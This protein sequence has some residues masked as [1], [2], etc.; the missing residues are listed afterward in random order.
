[1]GCSVNEIKS[2][3]CSSCRHRPLSPEAAVIGGEPWWAGLQVC[4]PIISALN[5][6]IISSPHLEETPTPV[7]QH[8]MFTDRATRLMGNDATVTSLRLPQSNTATRRRGPC[9]RGTNISFQEMDICGSMTLKHTQAGI[10]TH[11]TP[12]RTS[13]LAGAR[14]CSGAS[15]SS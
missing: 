9:S 1:M 15:G 12:R 3:L 10:N 14:T 13:M 11:D 6:D 7:Q 2:L 4:E 5:D 8:N